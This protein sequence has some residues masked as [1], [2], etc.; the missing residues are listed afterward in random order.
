MGPQYIECWKSAK[1]RLSMILS[2]HQC[3]T[4]EPMLNYIPKSHFL[5]AKIILVTGAGDGIGKEAALH[6]AR[7]GATVILLGKTV[8]KLEAVYDQILQDGGSEPAIVPLDLQGASPH[9]YVGLA[10]SIGQQ[11]GH[12]DGLLHNAALLSKLTPFLQIS[13]EDWQAVMQVNVNSQFYLTQALIPVLKKSQAAS[14]IFTT[15][16]VGLAGRAYW[17]PY[18][19]SKFATQGM[20]EVLADEYENSVIRFNCL[21][22]GATK[23]AMRAK[24][25]PAEN[26]NNLKTPADIMPWYLYLMDSEHSKEQG[27]TLHAQQK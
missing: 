25:Y 2:P 22:P 11:F 18:A 9:H 8:S 24:A 7:Y 26:A 14:V 1:N 21:N 13:I 3:Q 19:I 17:G 16:G 6:Y 10:D 4:S 15:S 23:T 27:I 20:M 5:K 12:L